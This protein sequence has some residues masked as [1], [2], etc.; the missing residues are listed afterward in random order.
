M[1]GPKHPFP[2]EFSW[3]RASHHR[4]LFFSD[5]D[6]IILEIYADI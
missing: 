4:T 5:L 3:P 6:G 1:M 2:P